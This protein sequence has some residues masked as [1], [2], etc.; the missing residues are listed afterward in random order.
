MI[1]KAF[2]IDYDTDN[3]NVEL[4]K[5]LFINI[6]NT[7]NKEDM[8]DEISDA[9]SN[10]TGFTHNGFEWDFVI[11]VDSIGDE[12]YIFGST[13]DLSNTNDKFEA[14]FCKIGEYD[15]VSASEVKVGYI[16]HNG[17]LYDFDDAT[18]Q[19]VLNDE[20]ISLSP[21]GKVEDCGNDDF[22]KWYFNNN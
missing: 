5:V 11:W 7:I 9:I 12:L 10:I 22:I 1:V 13:I 14:L 6:D 16:A 21:I 3:T 8:P 2:N 19:R 18:I 20:N 15:V 4:P 17:L